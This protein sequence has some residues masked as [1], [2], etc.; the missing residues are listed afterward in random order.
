MSSPM[1]CRL[2]SHRSLS[3]TLTLSMMATSS[4]S[5]LLTDCLGEAMFNE[6]LDLDERTAARFRFTGTGDD[7]VANDSGSDSR[8]RRPLDE[9]RI[10]IRSMGCTE[11]AQCDH[12]Q[13]SQDAVHTP[14]TE[15]EPSMTG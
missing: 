11:H 2:S 4:G 12:P 8:V 13:S 6:P 1:A 7:A 10:A 15:D 9:A 14:R 3:V 5:A